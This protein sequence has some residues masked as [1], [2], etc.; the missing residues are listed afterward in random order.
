MLLLLLTRVMELMKKLLKITGVS[1]SP[2]VSFHENPADNAS[3][4][5]TNQS[6]CSSNEEGIDNVDGNVNIQVNVSVFP[7]GD[8]TCQ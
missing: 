5:A 7:N 1:G 6:S 2:P 4:R 8:C 3:E